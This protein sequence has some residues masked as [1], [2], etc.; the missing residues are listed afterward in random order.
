MLIFFALLP[1]D[2]CNVFMDA[3]MLSV[4]SFKPEFFR[5][6]FFAPI[7]G[8]ERVLGAEW[9]GK[10]CPDFGFEGC[11]FMQGV[12]AWLCSGEYLGGT[13]LFSVG[14]NGWEIFGHLISRCFSLLLLRSY[15]M[16]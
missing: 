7:V 9:G 1:E 10:V 14:C 13:Q 8:N 5:L 12:R 4:S 11:Y 16:L 15:E 3:Q 2:P 6:I